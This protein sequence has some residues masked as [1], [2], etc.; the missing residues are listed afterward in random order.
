MGGRTAMTLACR[1]PDR[2]DG[3]I[4]LDA[5]P[6]DETGEKEQFGAFA[7]A[8]LNFLHDL[9]SKNPD[10]TYNGVVEAT[11]EYF[12]HKATCRA[13]VTRGLALDQDNGPNDR[14]KW[15]INTDI[16][17]DEFQN[18]TYFDENLRYEGPGLN[19][20]GGRSR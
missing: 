2:V 7:K 10:I 18:I 4:S 12:N 5:A 16:L 15:L 13:L 3:F 11:N 1:Y 20:V 9:K 6:V 8:V 19:I 17:R 14:A